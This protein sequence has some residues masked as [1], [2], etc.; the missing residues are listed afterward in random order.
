M[1]AGSNPARRPSLAMLSNRDSSGD[2]L[3]TTRWFIW[4]I[5]VKRDARPGAHSAAWLNWEAK[6]TPSRQSRSRCGVWTTGWPAA[7]RQSALNWS[8][9][10]KS[11]FTSLTLAARVAGGHHHRPSSGPGHGPDHT[12]PLRLHGVPRWGC[13]PESSNT[14]ETDQACVKQT[15][16]HNPMSEKGARNSVPCWSD[17]QLSSWCAAWRRAAVPLQR[18]TPLLAERLLPP[19]RRSAPFLRTTVAT[20]TL[21]TTAPPAMETRATND[22]SVS[23]PNDCFSSPSA[24]RIRPTIGGHSHSWDSKRVIGAISPLCLRCHAAWDRDDRRFGC[25]SSASVVRGLPALAAH[26][27]ALPCPGHRGVRSGA[28]DPHSTNVRG[29]GRGTLLGPTAVGLKLSATVG[30]L[31]IHDGFT[32]PWAMA[33]FI[34][35]IVGFVALAASAWALMAQRRATQK[36]R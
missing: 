22:P 9:V 35:E 29:S 28:N 11:T 8:R 17:W 4:Y 7:D 33:S 25:H 18:L 23:S 5:P 20:T 12:V 36:P 30:F 15:F 2:P 32:A 10:T 14:R 3:A 31:G 13:T 16:G 34:L 21:T 1:S 19:Q 24:P 27:S 26:R 6:R